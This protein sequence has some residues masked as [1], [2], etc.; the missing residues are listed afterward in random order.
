[1]LNFLKHLISFML[2]TTATD[3]DNQALCSVS[4]TIYNNQKIELLPV[5]I[6][7]ACGVRRL[8][9]SSRSTFFVSSS[10]SHSS[11]ISG[12]LQKDIMVVLCSTRTI[13]TLATYLCRLLIV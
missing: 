2:Y 5:L 13:L 8:L 7:T 9:I 12:S 4:L 3:Y 6:F 1:M 11:R 10:I